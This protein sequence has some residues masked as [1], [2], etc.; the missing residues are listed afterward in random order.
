MFPSGF[1]WV[2]NTFG[3]LDFYYQVAR[4]GAGTIASQMIDAFTAADFSGLTVDGFVSP[5]DPD[6]IGF[7]TAAFNPP[8]STTTTG[9]SSSGVTLQTNFGTSGLIDNEISATYIFRTNATQFT[10]GTF[11]IFDGSTYSGVAFAPT[12][13]VPEPA[14]WALMLV[15]FGV[16]G[17]A[18]RR[19]TKV[20]YAF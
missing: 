5:T 12:S 4:T 6:G 13:A 11:G 8:S 7:F 16:V 3:T 2:R 17:S 19:R 9:R 18:I 14:S 20:A 15:G 1:D 10:T